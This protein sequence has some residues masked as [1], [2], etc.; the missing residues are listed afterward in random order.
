MILHI[1]HLNMLSRTYSSI[2]SAVNEETPKYDIGL[3][4]SCN[5]TTWRKAIAIPYYKKQNPTAEIFNPQGEDWTPEMNIIEENVKKPVHEGGAK[6]LLFVINHETSGEASMVEASHMI[7][8][9]PSRVIMHVEDYVCDDEKVMKDVNRGR[10]ML[11][12]IMKQCGVTNY[13]TLHDA[14]KESLNRLITNNPVLLPTPDMFLV[15]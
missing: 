10:K 12:N 11:L 2:P 5:P 8:L 4:G 9:Y 6:Y 3:F 15:H 13:K 7:T 1:Y 14:L